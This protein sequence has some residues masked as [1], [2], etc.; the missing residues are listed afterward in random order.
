ML[1]LFFFLY[2]LLLFTKQEIF[3]KTPLSHFVQHYETLNYAAKPKIYRRDAESSSDQTHFLEFTAHGRKFQLA[4][5]PDVKT[6]APDAEILHGDGKRINFDRSS[7][8][9]GE[10]VGEPGSIV[11]GVLHENGLF[12]GKIHT[13]S[14]VYF[15]ESAKRYFDS[16]S[17]FHSVI[18]KDED[19]KY[20]FEF[21]E[22]KIAPLHKELDNRN[23]FNEKSFNTR[24]RRAT[25]DHIENNVCRLSMEAD[26]TFL[27]YAKGEILAVGE[28]LKHVQALNIIYGQTFNTSDAYFPYSLQFHVG[29]LQVHNEA[30]TPQALRR[31]NIDS[32][33][34]LSLM[35]KKDY[36]TFCQALYF[37]H[38]DFAGG[39]LGLAWI[40][41]PEGRA[42]GMC[43]PRHGTN[44]YNTAIVTFTLQGR[45]SPPKVSEITFAHEVGHAFGAAVCS[46]F[47]ITCSFLYKHTITCLYW[48]LFQIYLYN[49]NYTRLK[50]KK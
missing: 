24:N 29:L 9:I 17:G 14:G 47:C 2:H 3:A 39:I 49:Y 18:Y 45:T 46:S 7:L 31:E 34:F 42:G 4:L 8:L 37:T 19:V 23:D 38:R 44:S 50:V 25:T 21:A 5:R 28:I 27:K 12:T 11:H 13:K 22:P 20:D 6:I 32:S 26:F 16:P 40:G 43:D 30:Q 36:S 41:Y 48:H 35:S 10:V 33:T 15:I 1:A